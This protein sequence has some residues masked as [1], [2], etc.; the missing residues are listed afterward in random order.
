MEGFVPKGRPSQPNRALG[1][2]PPK[3]R[4]RAS[5]K[6]DRKAQ[7]LGDLYFA[8]DNYAVALEYYRRAL[9]DEGLRSET[10]SQESLLRIGTQIVECLRHRGD[11]NEAVEALHDLHRKLRPHV[12]RE[13]I[14]RLSSRLGILLFERGRYRT[15][16]RAASL[17]YRLLRDTTLNLDL[18][19]TE[20]CLGAVALR[21]GEWGAAREHFEGAI[22][23]YRRAD[24]QSG[25]AAAYNNLG[26]LHKN[27]CRFK[28]SV[29]FLRSEERRVGKE[30]RL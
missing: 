18:G 7:E 12:T 22:A 6:G 20:M 21:T 16:H 28:E 1:D 4:E 24:Y 2:P 30:C 13:Q 9:E 26:L 8:A 29:R 19:H 17:A 10:A 15:A 14:G 23:T 3:P 11:L 27:Q 5:A 25:M